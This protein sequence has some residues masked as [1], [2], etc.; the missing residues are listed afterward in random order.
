MI[1]VKKLGFRKMLDIICQLSDY[2]L[3]NEDSDPSGWR[4]EW[5]CVEELDTLIRG[6]SFIGCCAS[7]NN[8]RCAV[9]QKGT[10]LRACFGARGSVG[11]ALEISQ[12]FTI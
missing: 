10:C 7:A 12:R 5:K 4:N 8:S 9:G 11:E 2:Q 3:L 1:T 6:Y